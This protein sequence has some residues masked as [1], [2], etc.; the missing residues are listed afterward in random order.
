MEVIYET[1]T[2]IPTGIYIIYHIV[3]QFHTQHGELFNSVECNKIGNV[4]MERDWKW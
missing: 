2:Y 4:P 3:D 1:Q